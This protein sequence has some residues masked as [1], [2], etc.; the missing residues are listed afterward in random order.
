MVNKVMS[1]PIDPYEAD[2]HGY[3]L[4]TCPFCGSDK[5]VKALRIGFPVA[6]SCEHCRAEGP[7]KLTGREADTA[8]N[9]RVPIE[10]T[11]VNAEPSTYQPNGTGKIPTSVPPLPS[12]VIRPINKEDS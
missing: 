11:L 1:N 4:K 10:T 2:K 5:I 7:S 8:W 12:G 9:K 3:V 6:T